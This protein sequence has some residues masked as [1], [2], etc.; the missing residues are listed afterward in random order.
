MGINYKHIVSVTVV[1]TIMTNYKGIEKV[2]VFGWTSE[3]VN[4]RMPSFTIQQRYKYYFSCCIFLY[5]YV[6][7]LVRIYPSALLSE[8]AFFSCAYIHMRFFPVRFFPMCFF[9]VR[10]FP[11]T[12]K[13]IECKNKNSFFLRCQ[14]ND[15]YLYFSAQ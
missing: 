15:K 3:I 8:C 9:P 10:F 5:M 13:N 1:W 14:E 4:K 6:F 12:P 7:F 2:I 11:I